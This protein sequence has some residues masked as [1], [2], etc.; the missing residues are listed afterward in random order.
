MAEVLTEAGT[1]IPTVSAV[2]G[3]FNPL[4]PFSFLVSV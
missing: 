4:T 2:A 1:D 3:V